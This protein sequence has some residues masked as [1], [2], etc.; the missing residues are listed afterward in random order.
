MQER[1]GC[2]SSAVSVET[3]TGGGGGGGGGREV[4][5]GRGFR[6]TGRR[7]T[8]VAPAGSDTTS[9]GDRKY[10]MIGDAV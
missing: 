10:V 8:D 1:G 4:T 7:L 9:I 2:L 5:G 6:G 3:D